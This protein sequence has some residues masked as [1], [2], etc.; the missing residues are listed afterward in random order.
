MAF[1]AWDLYDDQDDDELDRLTSWLAVAVEGLG[2][3]NRLARWRAPWRDQAAC[4][5]S[6]VDFYDAGQA[7]AA[8]ALCASCGVVSECLDAG[9]QE[10]CGVWGGLDRSERR[11]AR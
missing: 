9:A 2:L 6:G 4:R 7:D 3:D 10:P 8:R 5:G 11:R 1:P